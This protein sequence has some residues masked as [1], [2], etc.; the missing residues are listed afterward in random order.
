KEVFTSAFFLRNSSSPLH[1]AGAFAATYHYSDQDERV[2]V[3]FK[4]NE[5]VNKSIQKAELQT[6]TRTTASF[7]ISAL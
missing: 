5:S 4:K 3:T 6:Y 1:K 2:E 7:K